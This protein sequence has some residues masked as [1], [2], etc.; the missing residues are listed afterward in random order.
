M[1]TEKGMENKENK[2]ILCT[3][4]ALE[5]LRLVK[6]PSQDKAIFN[7]EEIKPIVLAVIKLS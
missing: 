5:L 2:G 6:S 7:S 1:V 4:Q 3:M